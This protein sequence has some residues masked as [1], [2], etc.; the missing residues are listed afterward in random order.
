METTKTRIASFLAVVVASALTAAVFLNAED[1][2]RDESMAQTK[3]A[4][5]APLTAVSPAQAVPVSR[6]P[7]KSSNRSADEKAL[8][9]PV[10][11]PSGS[12]RSAVQL[13]SHV[14]PT[15]EAA[16]TPLSSVHLEWISQHPKDPLIQAWVAR[17]E[18]FEQEPRDTAWSEG[19]ERNL[20][21]H[22]G[23][24]T[25]APVFELLSVSCRSTRC[26]IQAADAQATENGMR[27]GQ[28][29][30]STM[31]RQPW[32]KIDIE[33]MQLFVSRMDGRT[34]YW[35]YLIRRQ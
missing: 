32:A 22:Y 27:E 19:I 24:K 23:K 21:D 31:L 25:T 14:M 17:H 5:S 7:A 20:F 16:P 13:S 8:T 33:D 1:E 11:R 15:S 10:A 4:S 26:E 29:F 28:Q 18:E 6:S 30:L 3:K 2:P 35:A 9:A 12:E 34:V